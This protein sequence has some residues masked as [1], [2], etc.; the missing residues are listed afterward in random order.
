MTK[1]SDTDTEEETSDEV[2]QP[3]ALAI[4]SPER[5][6]NDIPTL[7]GTG[8]PMVKVRANANIN[9]LRVGQTGTFIQSEELRL[10]TQQGF[11]TVVAE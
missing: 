7:L 3:G 1:K 8:A 5:E 10:Q 11:L 6:G 4:D 2:S 9:G